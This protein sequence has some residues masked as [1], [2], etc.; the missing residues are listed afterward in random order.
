MSWKISLVSNR[1]YSA[2]SKM[3]L[4]VAQREKEAGGAIIT[5]D[6]YKQEAQ[7]VCSLGKLVPS[8]EP[9]LW[10]QMGSAVAPGSVTPCIGPSYLIVSSIK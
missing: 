9:G 8:E 4:F 7:K 10:N 3:H 6:W 1:L 5:G 2:K